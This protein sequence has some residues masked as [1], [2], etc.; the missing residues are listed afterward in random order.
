[1]EGERERTTYEKDPRHKM[2]LG[3]VTNE[4]TPNPSLYVGVGGKEG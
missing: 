2:C 4:D 1:M 3:A